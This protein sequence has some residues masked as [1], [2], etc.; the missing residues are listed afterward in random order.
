MKNELSTFECELFLLEQSGF[1]NF[2]RFNLVIL[3]FV[4]FTYCI[5]TFA[6][7]EMDPPLY[8]TFSTLNSI[9]GA[10]VFLGHSMGNQIMRQHLVGAW[11]RCC[12]S[13]RSQ[14]P[15][16]KFAKRPIKK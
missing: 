10:L 12:G 13:G 6:Y 9:L 11:Q 8:G 1:L 4:L 3:F 2:Q 14:A 5:G 7:Y 16:R 15:R